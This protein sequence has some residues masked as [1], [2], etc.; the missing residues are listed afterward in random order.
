VQENCDCF[1]AA[2]KV[3]KSLPQTWE[4][5]EKIL[6]SIP[7]EA[8]PLCRQYQMVYLHTKN[9]KFGTFWT[10]LEWKILV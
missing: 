10:A 9:P 1:C 6:N 5:R 2:I 4:K 3:S 8:S 7:I